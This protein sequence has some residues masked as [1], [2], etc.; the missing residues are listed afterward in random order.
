MTTTRELFHLNADL[1]ELYIREPSQLPVWRA[2]HSQQRSFFV[3]D[4]LADLIAFDENL[5]ATEREAAEWIFPYGGLTPQ[6][7][8]SLH[9]RWRGP[10]GRD[11]RD[12]RIRVDVFPTCEVLQQ[13]TLAQPDFSVI[14]P[15]YEKAHTLQ[16]ALEFWRR[17]VGPRAEIILIDDGSP[18]T[19]ILPYIGTW[20][21]QLTLLRLPA[22]TPPDGDKDHRFRAGHARNAG[23]NFAR[24][25]KIIFVDCDILVPPD[26]LTQMAQALDDA[27]LVMPQRWQLHPRLTAPDPEVP[28]RFE[29]DVVLTPGAFWEDFQV[30]TNDWSAMALPWKW[31]SSFCLGLR[32]PLLHRIGGLRPTFV[33]YGFEDAELGY[34]AAVAGARFRLLPIHTH[35]LPQNDQDSQFGNS[36]DERTRLFRISAER[37]FRHHPHQDVF[38]AL[39]PWL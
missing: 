11:L 20:R 14:I 27:D 26:F 2:R 1:D 21:E 31:V 17:Q 6:Q 5:T 8:L 34:R 3:V 13:C 7:I 12:T 24:A 37:F 10:A 28:F 19:W 32:R 29:H 18:S 22:K 35:H 25:A 9:P 33:T 15:C 38:T 36:W 39:R 16:I 23:L 4:N 30:G